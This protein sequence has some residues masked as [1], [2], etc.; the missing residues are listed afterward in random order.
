[1]KSLYHYLVLVISLDTCLTPI[2]MP[3]SNSMAAQKVVYKP[4][5]PTYPHLRKMKLPNEILAI[6][7]Q[8]C[9]L[10]TC[11][12]MSQTCTAFLDMYLSSEPLLEEL[13]LARCPWILPQDDGSEIETWAQLAYVFFY[14]MHS[15]SPL[16]SSWS[17]QGI[18]AKDRG[19]WETVFG[20]E[21]RPLMLNYPAFMI[22]EP[23]EDDIVLINTTYQFP[24]AADF[25]AIHHRPVAEGEYL[26]GNRMII[27]NSPTG[28]FGAQVSVNLTTLEIKDVEQSVYVNRIYY[29][30]ATK[31][32]FYV[33]R[34]A[35][36][37]VPHRT[38]HVAEYVNNV[39]VLLVTGNV[40]ITLPL[41]NG[42]V[43]ARKRFTFSLT[44]AYMISQF[45]NATF[46]TAASTT[47][48]RVYYIH[49]RIRKLATIMITQNGLFGGDHWEKFALHN[50]IF[51]HFQNNTLVPYQV[52]FGRIDRYGF[53]PL[54][55][56]P[57]WIISCHTR[58][59]PAG[60]KL[61]QRQDK[62]RRYVSFM[63]FPNMVFDLS[64]RTCYKQR[65]MA[66]DLSYPHD[67][68]FAGIS[69]GFIKF[70]R[71]RRTTGA[72]DYPPN[73]RRRG[74]I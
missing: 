33:F 19:P 74:Y 27:T 7:Y 70:F 43:D 64:T 54:R 49:H 6:V 2:N 32:T 44:G 9:D 12:I 16:V 18:F 41:E 22:P 21:P 31:E 72:F 45:H 36:I 38:I 50:G 40:F 58:G 68:Y 39:E 8:Y 24:Y 28:V 5:R 15:Y 17:T 65:Q 53:V 48:Q 56:R 34:G 63:S 35:L 11:V 71:W 46:I 59:L 29:D 52:D 14:R 67:R 10:E 20:N 13:L 60:P 4:G 66:Y 73:N 1:M 3:L 23:P 57:N 47:S 37:P 51:W 69:M 62:L 61:L 30:A 25:E 55:T 26:E 42:E